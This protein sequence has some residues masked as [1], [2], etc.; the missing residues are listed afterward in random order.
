MERPGEREKEQGVTKS[1][2]ALL[3]TSTLQLSR[4]RA[5]VADS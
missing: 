3:D 4:S 2:C 1:S 5:S